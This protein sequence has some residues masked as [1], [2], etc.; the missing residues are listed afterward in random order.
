MSK[1][2]LI[3]D[4]SPII[5]KMLRKT[6]EENN[7][8]VCGDAKNGREGVELFEKLRPDITF[9]DVTMPVMDGLQAAKGIK[10]IDSNAGI[11]MLTAMGDN[12]IMEE[13]KSVGVDVFLKKPFNNYKIVSAI[14][15]LQEDI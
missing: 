12:K 8:D 4:D 14:S 9:M 2:V 3:V 1:R 5:H 11:I 7:F 15:G 10:A 6:L 13:A